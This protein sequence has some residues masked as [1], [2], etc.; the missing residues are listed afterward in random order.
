MLKLKFLLYTGAEWDSSTFDKEKVGCG[1]I[2]A[3][4]WMMLKNLLAKLATKLVGRMLC[5]S[6]KADQIV[7]NVVVIVKIDIHRD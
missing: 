2:A 1:I 7:N 3:E 4:R 5:R 6:K